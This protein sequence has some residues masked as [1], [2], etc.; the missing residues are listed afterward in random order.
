MKR[1]KMV[2]K[3]EHFLLFDH[4][5]PNEVV[6]QI[7]SKLGAEYILKLIEAAGMLPP[8]RVVKRLSKCPDSSE[9]MGYFIEDEH[10]WEPED[11]E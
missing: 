2:A 11:K 8:C 9:E 4:G 1:S 5:D 3:I 7:N 6:H 10:T